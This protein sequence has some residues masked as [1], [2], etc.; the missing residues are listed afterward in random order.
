MLTSKEHGFKTHK[1]RII[2]NGIKMSKSVRRFKLN[3]IG[4][5]IKV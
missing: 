5:N 3:D 1:G 4:E 2:I